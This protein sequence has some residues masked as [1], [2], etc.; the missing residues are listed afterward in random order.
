MKSLDRLI[1]HSSRHLGTS[2]LRSRLSSI[3]LWHCYT[4]LCGTS[5][6]C[7]PQNFLYSLA[8]VA[9]AVKTVAALLSRMTRFCC[10]TFSR[11]DFRLICIIPSCL[12][13]YHSFLSC[14]V[15]PPGL[16]VGSMTTTSYVNI[17]FVLYSTNGWSFN[18]IIGDNKMKGFEPEAFYKIGQIIQRE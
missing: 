18:Q 3:M 12:V 2:G 16:I 11:L 5:L 4:Q 6:F 10:L 7:F 9:H 15:Y 14:F 13:L 1:K 17:I 8:I